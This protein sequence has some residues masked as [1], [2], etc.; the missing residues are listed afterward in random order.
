MGTPD[1]FV[2]FV[3]RLA[4]HLDTGPADATG[5]SAQAHLSRHHFERVILALAGE[6]PTKFRGRILLERA[7][8][9]M[10]TTDATLLDIA[11]GAGFGSHEAFT[12][13]FRRAFGVAPSAWRRHPTRY[14]I[15]APSG[16]HFYPP[17]GLRLPARQRM[18]GMELIVAMVEHHVW[19]VEQLVARAEH[20]TDAQLD[21][22]FTGPVEGIDGE[23]LRWAFSRLVGQMEM[24]NAAMLDRE[25]DFSVEDHETLSSV[26][27]LAA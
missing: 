2:E 26:R 21:D 23:S 12:R 9:R 7:A 17:T 3:D 8:Y 4:A 22:P 25:Y 15:D 14:Q 1:R 6:S 18:D 16:V 5:L 19:V 24:W 27:S 11:V 13:A 20:L 10:I